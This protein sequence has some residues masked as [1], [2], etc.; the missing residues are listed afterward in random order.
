MSNHASGPTSA[1]CEAASAD[2]VAGQQTLLVHAAYPLWRKHTLVT[3]A[4]AKELQDAGHRVLVT[5]CNS[6]AGTCAVN[7]MGSPVACLICRNRVRQSAQEMGL[8]TIPLS[9]SQHETQAAPPL[10]LS[11]QKSLVE[12]VHS[13]IISTFRILPEDTARVSLVS[14]IKRRYYRTASRLLQSMKSVVELEKPARIEVFNGRH[15]CSRFAIIAATSAHIPFNTLEITAKQQ[16]ILHQGH[17]V[18]DRKHIQ[19]RILQQPADM[20]TA[21]AFYKRRRQPRSNKFAKKHST[22]FVPPSAAGYKRR[23]SVF[24]SSQDEFESL[25]RDW[26]SPFPDYASVLKVA[27]Q[28]HPE[29]LFCIRFHPNQSDIV[30]DIITPFREIE[31][32]P[33]ARVYYPTDT[34]NTY[35]LVDWS[36]LVITFGSTVTV[37][38]CWAGKP[39]IMLGPSYF[40]ELDVSYNPQTAEKFAALL[41]QSLTAKDRTNAARFACYQEFDSDPL[42]YIRH[43]GR[44]LMSNGFRISSPWLS[45]LARSA[46]NV[47]CHLVKQITAV[48]TKPSDE[49]RAA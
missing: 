48:K 26:R 30:S 20:Q 33:N 13:G 35:T 21:E 32:L 34:A 16:P 19:R 31:T 1:T 37:E 24:L 15:A 42:R 2:D 18:H 29:D 4:R 17:L 25:G 5:Y 43:D 8:P 11:E 23:I 22:E 27:C 38:A 9:T 40:D 10:R 12:G 3:L 41:Q 47:L 36:D 49:K 45:Q 7:Y 6:T 46:D 28:N 14:R 39:V 44:R